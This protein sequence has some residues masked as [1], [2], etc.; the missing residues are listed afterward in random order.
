[1]FSIIFHFIIHMLKSRH[2][3]HEHCFV[4]YVVTKSVF[5]LCLYFLLSII[6]TYPI[7]YPP[8]VCTYIP[9]PVFQ[10]YVYGMYIQTWVNKKN[11]KKNIEITTRVY[12]STIGG[13]NQSETLKQPRKQY[14][15]MHFVFVFSFW[16]WSIKCSLLYRIRCIVSFIESFIMLKI[17]FL[18]K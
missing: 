8:F 15:F 7:T 3:L 12:A 16:N 17:N 4:D 13:V 6:K 11:K 9:F 14:S 2:N 18:C 5:N 1:M 10:L